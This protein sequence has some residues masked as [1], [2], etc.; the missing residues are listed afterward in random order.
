VS[1]C[2]SVCLRLPT[3]CVCLRLPIA[4][5]FFWEGTYVFI[6]ICYLRANLAPVLVIVGED[7]QGPCRLLLHVRALGVAAHSRHQDLDPALRVC[8][9]VCVCV[10]AIADCDV[11]L[12][13]GTYV[14]ICIRYLRAD[15]ALVLG[16]GG[17]VAQGRGRL[18]LHVRA[19][20]V[21]AHRRDQ[22]LQNYR[23]HAF[24]DMGLDPRS[25]PEISTPHALRL[26]A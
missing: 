5:F 15:L 18:L 2:A 23:T 9:S 17:E 8:V 22:K 20:G 4:T 21:A 3:D 25:V 13:E 14:F 7:V 11:F 1:V 19:L 12:W 24:L 10:F 16:I 26:C 6:C